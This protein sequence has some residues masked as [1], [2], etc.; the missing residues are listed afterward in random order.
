M[1]KAEFLHK[2]EEIMELKTGSLA[3]NER[4]TDLDEWDSLKVVEFL[5]LADEQFSLAVAPKA[6]AA[7]KT[8]DDLRALLGEYVTG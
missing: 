7:C 8:I 6:I 3:G 4:L 1:T 2:L 5:A